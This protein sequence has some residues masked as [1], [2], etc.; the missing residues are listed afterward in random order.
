MHDDDFSHDRA[1]ARAREV[2]YLRSLTPEERHKVLL[3]T[4][5]DTF[6]L[7]PGGTAF[8]KRMLKV[9]ASRPSRRNE[10]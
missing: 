6:E 9:E 7:K 2:A 5:S 3:K 10:P 4:I 8:G 1:S